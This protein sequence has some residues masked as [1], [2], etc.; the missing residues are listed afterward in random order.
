MWLILLSL[1]GMAQERQW[2]RVTGWIVAVY[3]SAQVTDILTIWFW[4][5]GGRSALD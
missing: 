4:E 5:K 1:F 3:L 2:R